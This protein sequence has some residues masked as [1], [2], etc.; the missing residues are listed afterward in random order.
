MILKNTVRVVLF[1]LVLSILLFFFKEYLNDGIFG[2]LSLL[3]TLSVI[4][5][6]FV[7]F[8]E[9][10]HPTQTITWLVVLGSFPLVGFFFYLLFGRNYRK[11]KM[12]RKKYFL[13]KQ[14]FLTVEGKDDPRSE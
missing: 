2:F 1:L 13:D 11:E 8:L 12:Y 3:I 7:I 5:I 10:R 9:N 6:G 4:F 14:A